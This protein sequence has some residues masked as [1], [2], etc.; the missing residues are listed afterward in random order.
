M[1]ARELL[2]F[3]RKRNYISK[4]KEFDYEKMK[5]YCKEQS[6]I[7]GNAGGRMTCAIIG[8]DS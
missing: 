8:I 6:L 3:V 7:N 1:S 2:D 5:D 4:K